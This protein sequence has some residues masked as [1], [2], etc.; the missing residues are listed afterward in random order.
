MY[1]KCCNFKLFVGAILCMASTFANA[2]PV[3]YTDIGTVNAETYTFTAN[4]TGLLKA[5]YAGSTALFT[6]TLG[7]LVNGIESEIKG[8]NTKSARYGDMLNFGSVTEGDT[9]VFK[10]NITNDRGRQSEV[11]SDPLMNSDELNHVF[12]NSYVGDAKIPAGTYVAF[13]DKVLNSNWNY[14]DLNFVFTNV[15]A[16][17]NP[18]PVPAAVWLFGSGLMGLFMSRKRNVKS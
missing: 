13:E 6:N 17:V 15:R 7:L 8:L 1:M 18:V 9:L 2:A 10:I 11:F 5:Y 14:F 16:Q 12:S 3:R 4:S